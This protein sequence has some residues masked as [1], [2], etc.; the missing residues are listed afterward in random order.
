MEVDDCAGAK[1]MTANERENRHELTSEAIGGEATA[2]LPKLETLRSDETVLDL[3]TLQA[4]DTVYVVTAN[5]EYRIHVVDPRC[6][7]V[8]VQGGTI[9]P[10]P[11]ESDVFGTG[12]D[13]RPCRGRI[14]VGLPLELLA[15]T[16]RLRTSRVRSIR[17]E[18]YDRK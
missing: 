12:G 2:S 9:L 4:D 13:G 8:L 7:R 14:G 1:R 5:S 3:E 10:E 6:G 18:R 15:G 17:V 16:K 11:T